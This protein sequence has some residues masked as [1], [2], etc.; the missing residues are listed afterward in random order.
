MVKDLLRKSNELPCSPALSRILV[1]R[2]IEHSTFISQT[3][4]LQ[5]NQSLPFLRWKHFYRLIGQTSFLIEQVQRHIC[6][7]E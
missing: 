2:L 7:R 4:E 6:I 3:I 5:T 1:G